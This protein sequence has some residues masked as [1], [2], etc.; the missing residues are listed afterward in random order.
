MKTTILIA[1][2][3]YEF[4][5]DHLRLTLLSTAAARETVQQR[6]GFTTSAVAT[7]PPSFGP[8]ANTL[9]PG[10]VF[11]VGSIVSRD[12]TIIPIRFL[13]FEPTRVVIDTSTPSSYLDEVWT[14]LTDA[15]SEIHGGGGMTALAAPQDVRDYSAL[16]AESEADLSFLIPT[17]LQAAVNSALGVSVQERTL[18]PTMFLQPV[19][20]AVKY[21]GLIVDDPSSFQISLRAGSFPTERLLFSGAPLDT[22]SH[23]QYLAL[24]EQNLRGGPPCVG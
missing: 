14:A 11:N 8:I 5:P 19:A 9:P 6:F 16:S 12:G 21:D 7:P 13:N 20:T 24:L 17:A 2:R 15:L 1:R 22:D 3:A 18:V 23:A 4:H 10:V